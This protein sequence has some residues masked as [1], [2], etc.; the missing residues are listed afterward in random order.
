M[1]LYGNLIVSGTSAIG[2]LAIGSSRNATS[3]AA[4]Q[5][6]GD[7][8]DEFDQTVR[9]TLDHYDDANTF[10]ENNEFLIV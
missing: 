9:A 8:L 2:G 3:F 4:P 5:L 1:E 6:F 7:R 10:E